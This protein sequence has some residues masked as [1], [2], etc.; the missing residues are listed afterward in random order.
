MC[1]RLLTAHPLQLPLSQP[2]SPTP[3]ATREPLEQCFL[4]H[5]PYLTCT[6]SPEGPS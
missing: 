6:E 3:G 5:D 4:K 2:P 1:F